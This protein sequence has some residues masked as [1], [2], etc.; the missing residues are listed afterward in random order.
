MAN[1][2]DQAPVTRGQIDRLIRDVNDLKDQGPRLGRDQTCMG[3]ETVPWLLISG[4]VTFM[5]RWV[6]PPLA[7]VVFL[8][9]YFG[10]ALSLGL[11]WLIVY[12]WCKSRNAYQKKPYREWNNRPQSFLDWVTWILTII[13]IILIW[14]LYGPDRSQMK[15][16]FG[17]FWSTV[18]EYGPFG[19][20]SE[21]PDRSN[22]STTD[23]IQGTGE[24]GP[25]TGSNA[26]NEGGNQ[27]DNVN[28]ADEVLTIDIVARREEGPD[29]KIYNILTNGNRVQVN[30]NS[31]CFQKFPNPYPTTCDMS[32]VCKTGTNPLNGERQT[33]CSKGLSVPLD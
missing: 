20:L 21:I 12:I 15:S 1:Q 17:S 32:V 29:G 18:Q 4:M 11:V 8:K 7:E 22:N 30:K 5:L 31:K 6:F 16:W 13:V 19:A 23:G 27:P 24:T 26:D 10:T 14:Q 25:I 2:S 33:D 9:V 28:D 3:W